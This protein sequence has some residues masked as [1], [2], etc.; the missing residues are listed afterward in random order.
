LSGPPGVVRAAAAGGEALAGEALMET[1]KIPPGRAGVAQICFAA[2]NTWFGEK[3]W[4]NSACQKV[5]RPRRP[6]CPALRI[7]R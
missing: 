2:R 7:G 4:V 3:S 6:L 5:K 1:A